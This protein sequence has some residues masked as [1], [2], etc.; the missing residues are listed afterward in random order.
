MKEPAIL[1]VE[2]DQSRS[3]ILKGLLLNHE[4]RIIEAG[5]SHDALQISQT[6]CPDLVLIG[7]SGEGAWGALE[8]VKQVRQ[9]DRYLPLILINSYSSEE[10]AIAALRAG[11]NDY[12]KPPWCGDELVASI[13]RNLG[14]SSRSCPRNDA[15]LPNGDS[16][17]ECLIGAGPRMREIKSFL[18]F[19]S[20]T[21]SNVLI[22]G[23]T[24]TGKE[25]VAE[26]IHQRSARHSKPLIRINCA[27]IPDS[28]LESE[29]FG[30]E[31]GAFTGAHSSY[32]GKL[33][34]AEGGTVF[35]DEIGDMSPYGQAKILRVIEN[36]ETYRLGGKRV[37]PLNFRVIAATNQDLKHL[38]SVNKFRKDLYFRLNVARVHLPPLRE[39]NE[40]IPLLLNHYVREFNHHFG[41]QSEGFEADALCC[42]V[43]YE[44]PGNVRELKNLLEAIFIVPHGNKITLMDL[45]ESLRGQ[46]H[47]A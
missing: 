36:K 44:W 19:L 5:D 30:Y 1:I 4:F 18:S 35:F 7:S 46:H 15:R 45:P 22:T 26:L 20:A 14:N 12:F 28:L 10:Q 6:Q 33:K 37:I 31:K 27:A 41:W 39:Q 42:L 40:D 11:V 8:L 29:L 38:I 34:H 24:G 32:D 3:R 9:V 25:R 17:D 47:F 2:G 23:E 16:L 21:D 43:H 13:R